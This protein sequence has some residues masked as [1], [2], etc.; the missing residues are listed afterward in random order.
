MT[1]IADDI[2][3]A[4]G[5]ANRASVHPPDEAFET[6]RA[7]VHGALWRAWAKLVPDGRVTPVD[8]R[9]HDIVDEWLRQKKGG[10]S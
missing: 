3:K 10:S 8:V 7:E 1:D 5:A 9:I 6:I 2:R 4:V